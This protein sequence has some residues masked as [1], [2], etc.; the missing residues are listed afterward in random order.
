MLLDPVLTDGACVEFLPPS[1]HRPDGPVDEHDTRDAYCA[2]SNPEHMEI[3]SILVLNAS[4]AT[5]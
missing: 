4:G 3:S 5:P 2:E 1:R